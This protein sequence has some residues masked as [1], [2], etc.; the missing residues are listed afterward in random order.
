M[1]GFRF[2][3]MERRVWFAVSGTEDKGTGPMVTAVREG[4]NHGLSR[5]RI[6]CLVLLDDSSM[7]L[8]MY[9]K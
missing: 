3:G 4:E 9:Q 1:W 2:R 6:E 8:F 7:W 5:L